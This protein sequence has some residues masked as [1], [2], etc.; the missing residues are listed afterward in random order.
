MKIIIVS[1]GSQG[2][3]NPFLSLGRKLKSQG[4]GVVFCG[5]KENQSINKY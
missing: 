5:S 1:Q 3:I 2:D 4:H